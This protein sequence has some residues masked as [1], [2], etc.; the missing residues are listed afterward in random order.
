MA[1]KL[2]RGILLKSGA[3]AG[4][5]LQ[6]WRNWVEKVNAKKIDLVAGP[7]FGVNRAAVYKRASYYL[8]Q[9]ASV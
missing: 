8:G 2:D 3:N 6:G 7:L 1:L 4:R 5:R 9:K